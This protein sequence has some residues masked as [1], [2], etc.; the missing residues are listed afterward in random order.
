MTQAI[1]HILTASLAHI[2]FLEGQVQQADA[3]ITSALAT[4][5]TVR[6][7]LTIPGYGPVFSAGVGAELGDYQRFLA[8]QK[9]DPTHRRYR[10]R[11]LRD[12]ED[13]IAK[14]AGLWW[15]QAQS[16]G[17]AAE[18]RHLSKAGNR[19]LRYYL[20]QGAEQL[21]KHAPEYHRFYAR[22][23][24]EASKH[25]HKRA[26]VLTARKSIGLIIGLLHRD[27]PYRS[28]EERAT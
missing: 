18:D 4:A 8:G 10:P 7:L 2:A 3:W 1:Q 9:W 21:R 28:E 24:A 15:P 11:N 12:A 16:G 17:F 22:K 14:I 5:P 25:K 26:L 23:Y 6:R 20:I 13:A 27:E 19:Y